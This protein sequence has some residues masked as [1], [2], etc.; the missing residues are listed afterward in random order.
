MMLRPD[1]MA[2]GKADSFRTDLSCVGFPGHEAAAGVDVPR[3][4]VSATAGAEQQGVR[5]VAQRRHLHIPDLSWRFR[6]LRLQRAKQSRQSQRRSASSGLDLLKVK[7][8]LARQHF[9][10]HAFITSRLD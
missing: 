1:Q 3:A 4:N 7:P 10:I 2:G 9:E 5:V 8:L 6:P